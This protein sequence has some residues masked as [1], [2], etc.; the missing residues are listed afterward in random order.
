MKY[1]FAVALATG[2]FEALS[3][4]WLNAPD[5]AGQVT[6]GVA[7][8]LLLTCA[9]VMWSRRSVLA[10]SVIGLL[11][12]VD[13]GSTPFYARTSWVDWV[14]QPAFVAVGLVGIVAW[15]DVLR[16]RSTVASAAPN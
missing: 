4:A 7:A 14:I 8:A 12:V 13:V 11:L 16:R 1:L 15:I 5:V 6:A 9:W 3:A 2:T 10:A